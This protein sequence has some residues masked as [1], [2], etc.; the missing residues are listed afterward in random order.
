MPF[1]TDAQRKAFFAKLKNGLLKRKGQ[2][3][4]LYTGGKEEEKRESI[5]Y[6]YSSRPPRR[7]MGLTREQRSLRT[8]GLE[9]KSEYEERLGK[10]RTQQLKLAEPE[11]K[12][13]QFEREKEL[14]EKELDIEKEKVELRKDIFEEKMKELDVKIKEE[15]EKPVIKRQSTKRDAFRGYGKRGRRR[16]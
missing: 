15:I 8:L 2:K 3:L 10:W 4:R 13:Q 9:S 6:I 7:E 16:Y 14:K 11:M 5:D 1:K 12:R